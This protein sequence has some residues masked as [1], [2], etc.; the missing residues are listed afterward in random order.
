MRKYDSEKE[1]NSRREFELIKDL[2]HP[3]IIKAIEFIASDSWTY[4]V[5]EK[6]EGQEL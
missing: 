4:F 1:A 6:A 5:M 2:S 3:H